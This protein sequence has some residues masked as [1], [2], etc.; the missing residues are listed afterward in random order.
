MQTTTT[1]A[2]PRRATHGSD[3]DRL[4]HVA[5][6]QRCRECWPGS[7]DGLPPL[8]EPAVDTAPGWLDR[9]IAA[10]LGVAS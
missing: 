7:P 3:A 5:H 10:E 8:P 1:F 2:Y 4:W 9:L 6:G